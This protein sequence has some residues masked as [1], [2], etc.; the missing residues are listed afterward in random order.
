MLCNLSRS[1]RRDE[2]PGLI[3]DEYEREH[4]SQLPKPLSSRGILPDP[5]EYQH[6][7]AE[8]HTKPLVVN[9]YLVLLL[10]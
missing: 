1:G 8:E 4:H 5:D 3:K 2:M 9:C 10:L 7:N 6:S